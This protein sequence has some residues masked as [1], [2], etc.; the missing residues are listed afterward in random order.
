ME[1]ILIQAVVLAQA[2]I[3]FSLGI[4]L[5]IADFK[6][7]F[8]RPYAFSIALVCQLLI[9]PALAFATVTFFSF[10]PVLAAGL[11]ILSFC[12]GGV[13]SNIISKVSQGDVALSVSLTAVVS[14]IS[15]ITVPP[16][17]A[18]AITYFMAEDAI[19]FSFYQLALITFLIT[20]TPVSIGVFVRHNWA[21]L[22]KKIEPILEKIALA[23]WVIIVSA[24]IA[25]SFDKLL[26]NFQ[27][28]GS[29]LMAL[30]L[31]MAFIGVFVSY[32]F[33][34]SIKESKTISIESS[35][36][37]SPMAITL[38]T[39]ITGASTEIPDLALPAAVY[40]VTM[41]LVAIPFVLIFRRWNEE[42]GRKE[43]A[44]ND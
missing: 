32:I 9:L 22:A 42:S 6:R 14:I 21:E 34:L 36:Q 29:G 4:G 39:A 35:I 44:T 16:L 5:E 40:S 12:P 41:Y 43:L 31:A 3:M 37:N 15:F 19:E 11:M 13:T 20:T 1:L 7:V 24:A 38:A 27:L 2:V 10:P 25:K 17:I 26:E 18:W 30:P 28:I 23:L 8:E 33:G